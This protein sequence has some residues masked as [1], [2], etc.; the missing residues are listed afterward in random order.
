MRV[1]IVSTFFPLSER[2]FARSGVYD[3]AHMLAKRG[4]EVHV[5][6]YRS[7]RDASVDGVF[8]H[9]VKK[10]DLAIIP[11]GIRN[12]TNFPVSSFSHPNEVRIL[13]TY[14]K[15]IAKIAK[16]Y[17]VDLIHA[18]FSYP[19]GFAALLAK[20][21][22]RKILIISV[23]GYDVQSDP[24]TGYG[25]LSRKYTRDMVVKALNGAD[26]ITVGAESHYEAVKNL[27]GKNKANKIFFIH[28]S[29]DTD[30]FSPSVNGSEIRKKYNIKAHQPVVLFA[31]H[32][33]PVYGA[34]YLIRA[35]A[36]VISKHSK[37]IFLII[38]DGPL[39]TELQE[40]AR[41]IGMDRNMVF[42]GYVPKT[43]MPYYHAASDIFVD[44]CIYGQG[45]ASMEALSC[46]KPVIGFKTGQIRVIHKVDSYLVET[47]D[48]EKLAN[49]MIWLIENPKLRKEM[50]TKGRKRM[51]EQHGFENRIDRLIELYNHLLRA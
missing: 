28:P 49:K 45:Y 15:E 39:K 6:S 17:D 20:A 34:E 47:G 33:K 27:I 21:I 8:V 35:A 12:L 1:L 7:E 48:I 42:I 25:S 4:I 36:R 19:D 5:A 26:A 29:L 13:S 38:G 14:G 22:V 30:L 43:E 10:V 3:E 31:R 32:L 24:K 9:K 40:L 16:N 50:G 37:T 46:G 2:D 51:V 18:H 41:R 11:F 44:P 23:W